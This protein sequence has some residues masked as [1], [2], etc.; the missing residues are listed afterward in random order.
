M[1][2]ILDVKSKK[3]FSFL[4]TQKKN[5]LFKLLWLVYFASNLGRFSYVACMIEIV[6][7]EK[8]S[9]TQ[10]GLVVTG[11]FIC[12]G[13]GQIAA[14]YIG[15]RR[16]PFKLIFTGLFCTAL[17]HLLMI[18]ANNSAYMLVIW[19][20]N[21]LCQA[22]LWPPV[23][24]IIVESYSEPDR[25]RFCTNIATTHPIAAMFAYISCA[26]IITI[27][28]WKAV[29][30][31]YSAFLFLVA[32]IWLL[33][34]HK[35]NFTVQPGTPEKPKSAER[36][37]YGDFFA[38]KAS[39]GIAIVLFCLTLV[40]QG[41]LRDGLMTWAPAYMAG[42]FSLPSNSAIFSAG[43]IPVMN[44]AGIYL[45]RILFNRF[46]NEGTITVF[47]FGITFLAALVLRFAGENHILLAISSF[48]VITGCMMGVNLMLVTFV[49]ARFIKFNLVPFM[50]GL[51]N[52]MV[53]AGSSVSTFSVASMA[54][55]TGW[56]SILTLMIILAVISA[57]LCVIAAPRWK[58]FITIQ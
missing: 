57:M 46:N 3:K 40:I 34:Y 14:G 15:G 5:T 27:L 52:F 24:R 2:D 16:N 19:C 31:I 20:I 55:K 8:I 51:T 44:L 42:M 23:L 45:C 13:L 49:P 10:A 22:I 11:F 39:P 29:F 33:A 26:G 58:H 38:G 43:F 1:Q 53:Y 18:F 47:L 12:Y 32:G 30:V 9:M 36:I 54:E 28:S 6:I 25:S 35:L 21:G 48:A 50:T 41:A 37:R 17:M 56:N 4:P 7:T